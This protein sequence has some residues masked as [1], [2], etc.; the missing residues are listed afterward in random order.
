MT[1][2]P[3]HD[4]AR[5]GKLKA[6]PADEAMPGGELCSLADL[7][8]WVEYRDDLPARPAAAAV[9]EKLASMAPPLYLTNCGDWAKR[10]PAD[11][12]WWPKVD[13]RSGGVR[14]QLVRRGSNWATN[15]GSDAQAVRYEERRTTVKARTA[16]PGAYGDLGAW[17]VLREAWCSDDKATRDRANGKHGATLAR[18]AIPMP[19]AVELFGYGPPVSAA[20]GASSAVP[21]AEVAGPSSPGTEKCIVQ[22][23]GGAWKHVEGAAWTDAERVAMFKMRHQSGMSGSEL[24]KVVGVSRQRIDEQIGAAGVKKQKSPAWPTCWQPSAALLQECGFSLAPLQPLQSV[25]DSA[26]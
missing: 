21:L 15:W 20:P 17:Q 14:N 23:E 10:L 8:A 12:E 7:V 24:E 4:A 1:F 9:V 25:F 19:A 13:G 2:E 11:F 16:S 3:N 18:L 26:A 22:P 5:L 6:A